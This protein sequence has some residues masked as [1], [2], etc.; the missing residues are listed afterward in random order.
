MLE[1]TKY[2]RNAVAAS[3]QG[4][5][6]YKNYEFCSVTLDELREGKLCKSAINF[7]WKKEYEQDINT[8]DESITEVKNIIIALKTISTEFSE[9][10]RIENHVDE[11]T[12]IFFLPANI[13]NSGQLVPSNDG[14]MPWIPREY[15][16]PM[17]EPLLAIGHSDKYDQYMEITT[18]VRNQ[19][20][21]WNKYLEYA[22]KMYEFV[23]G[24]KFEDEF[25]N[26]ENEKIKLDGKYYVFIDSTVN[27]TAH[28]LQLY[29]HL[30]KNEENRLYS[31]LTNGKI[32]PS[33]Q[34]ILNTNFKKMKEHVGQMGGEYSLSPSQREAIN[35]FNEIAEGDILSVSGPPGTGKTTL[36]QSIVANM[37]VNAALN[38]EEAPIIVASSTNNQAVTNIIDSFGKIDEIGLLNLEKKWITGSNSFATYFP[39]KGK[40]KEAQKNN[41]QY[42]TVNGGEFIETLESKENRESSK[43]KFI[44]EFG[45]YFKTDEKDLL[46]CN[47]ILYNKLSEINSCRVN[48]VHKIEKIKH[49]LENSS[50]EAYVNN[51]VGCLNIKENK[52]LTLL[53][54][55]ENNKVESKRYLD[56]GI[57]WRTAYDSLPL[58]VRILKFLPYFMNKILAWSFLFIQ[59]EELEFLQRDM[60]IEEIECKY[61]EKINENDIQLVEM[62]KYKNAI[63]SEIEELTQ[64]K[65]TIEKMLN[66]LKESFH[67]LNEYQILP[68]KEKEINI[69]NKFDICELNDLLD[70][71]RYAEFWFAVHYY[72]S[73]WL[74]E[75]NPISEKQKGKTFENVL[76]AMYHRL[77]MISPC[78]VMTFFM[79]PKQFLAYNGNEKNNYYMYNYID[80]LIVDEAGQISPEIAAPSFSLAKKAVVVGDEEQIPPVWGTT[81]ALDISIAISNKVIENKAQYLEL[82]TNGLNCSQSSIMK[83]ASLSCAYEKYKK[84]LFLCEHRRCYNEIILYCNELVYGGKLEPKRGN[85]IDNKNNV[86]EGILPAMGH[87]QISTVRSQKIG[88]SRQNIEEAQQIVVWIKENYLTLVNCYKK[89]E[90]NEFEERSLI[91]VITPFKS[92]SILINRILKKEIPEFAKYIDVGTVH[93]FQG[94]ERKIIIFSSVYG[95]EDGCYFINRAPNLMNVAVSRAKDS[96]LVFGESGCLNGGEKTAAGLL[97]IMTT[98]IVE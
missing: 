42:T 56:R 63:I 26:C 65:L 53:E 6:E 92:Q 95:N 62:N 88:C 22:V 39:S 51:L 36:L 91:G 24:T 27:S 84:G 69:W 80:L 25:I 75:E 93:T 77:A 96:F 40:F 3:S 17:E 85:S 78:M 44:I 60:K 52:K 94:A 79:L 18:D 73:R 14:K 89:R 21:S 86:L 50:Y 20:D 28:I 48:C 9:S 7:L 54:R 11:M 29:N 15:L 98:T 66:E 87:K 76:N 72:E 41:Y 4:T 1:I 2:F 8:V 70:R 58:H 49:I 46:N 83:L 74:I 16:Y 5:I 37:Y 35:H 10:S 43:E 38:R 47:N 61:R 31:K 19:I 23:T 82:E 59:D 57:A 32:E 68:A 71:V 90:T 67:K 12:S 81:R 33:K 13:N 34:L 45:R 55:I 30:Q 97:K 64:K